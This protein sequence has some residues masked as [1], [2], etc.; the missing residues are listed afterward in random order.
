MIT[1]VF[2]KL[3]SKNNEIYDA[4]T[5]GDA[6]VR[7]ATQ[8]IKN[9]ISEIAREDNLCIASAGLVEADEGEWLFDI[10]LYDLKNDGDFSSVTKIP[11]VVESEFSK[12]TYGGFK[13]DFDKLFIA[14]SS[15]R[16]FLMRINNT[17]ELAKI[18][19]YGQDSVNAFEPFKKGEG[20]HLIYWDEI[21]TKNFKHV[22]F[23]KS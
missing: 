4:Y 20:I 12:S 19:K 18:L 6:R 3:I 8:I 9:S 23:A 5:S 2:E 1:R 22:F 10:V 14:T 15:E 21:E 11:L 17:I 16:L 13:E 7:N